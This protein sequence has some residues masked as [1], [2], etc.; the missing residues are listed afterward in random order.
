MVLR[1]G[2]EGMGNLYCVRHMIPYAIN[3]VAGRHIAVDWMPDSLPSEK[4]SHC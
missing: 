3:L 1:A 4:V 2:G